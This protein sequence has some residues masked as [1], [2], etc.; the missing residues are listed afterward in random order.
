MKPLK[1]FQNKYIRKTYLKATGLFILFAIPVI[2]FAF[3]FNKIIEAIFLFICFVSTRY[4][5]PKTFHS[6]KYKC[7]LYSIMMFCGMIY[8]VIPTYISIISSVFVSTFASYMLYKIQDYLDLKKEAQKTLIEMTDEEFIK[9]C[10]HKNL[11]MQETM[12]ADCIIRKNLKGNEL[13]NA[14]GYSKRQT[15]NI[16]KQIFNKLK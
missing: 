10:K 9:H 13:Y 14:I 3:L 1:F 6:T 5:F 2:L 16:R 11:T 12:I 4:T 8:V 7:I 15:I